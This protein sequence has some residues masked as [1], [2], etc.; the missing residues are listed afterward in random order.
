MHNPFPAAEAKANTLSPIQMAGQLMMPAAFI[1]DEEDEIRAMEQMIAENRI[2]GICFFHSRASAATNFEGKRKIPYN[3]KSLDRLR[4]LIARYSRAAAEP[5]LIA[6]DAEWGLAM[7]VENSPQ[8]P[9]ALA[10]GAL[11]D[12]D[13]LL[14]ET[15]LR[16]AADCLE[17]GIH[18]D[19]T[20]VADVN[21]D[22]GNPVI[23]YRSFGG[24]AESVAR[25]A[26]HVYR[27]LRDGGLLSCAKHFPGHGDTATD[28]H[29]DLPVLDKSMSQL[30]AEEFIPFRALIDEGIPAV[31]TGH[32]S[33]PALDPEGTPASLSGVL[34]GEVLRG[35]LGFKGLVI[36]DALNMH[37]VSKRFPQP[38]EVALRALQAGNDIL[39]FVNDVPQALERIANEVPAAKIR[40]HFLRVWQVKEQVFGTARKPLAPAFSP[41]ELNGELAGK[42]LT[43]LRSG[44]TLRTP[45]YEEGFTLIGTG[46]TALFTERLREATGCAYLEWD[47]SGAGD[48]FEEPGTGNVLLALAPP[49]QKPPGRFGIS[50]TALT[51]L[52]ELMKRHRV[53]LYHFGN[54]YALNLPG[55]DGAAAVLLAYQHLPAFQAAA[56]LHFLENKAVTGR[57]PVNLTP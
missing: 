16:M 12:D 50:E 55:L 10:L 8:Y 35:K 48:G 11:D 42:C 44:A 1:N 26:V 36:T 33:V 46:P 17:A 18:W 52:S 54:P 24:T 47:L 13:P 56:S 3:E 25:K 53:W 45:F 37:A 21:T 14:Y 28:S 2:G 38:G 15:G 9:Y 7:R 29:L 27:G 30:E 31:M 4:E 5:L 40:E 19:L 57:L 49:S 41:E 32:L 20:P 43:E 34:I 39:C 22:P 51:K 6:M 23:G